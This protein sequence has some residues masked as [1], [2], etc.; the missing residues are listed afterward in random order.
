MKALH[1]TK[2]K[3][4]MN[5]P[6]NKMLIKARTS[7]NGAMVNQGFKMIWKNLQAKN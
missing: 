4:K 6:K 2:V 5:S 3:P 1:I 7:K